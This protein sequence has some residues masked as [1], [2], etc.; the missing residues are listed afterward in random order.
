[1]ERQIK[2][3]SVSVRVALMWMLMGILPF[4]LSAQSFKL[5]NGQ[6]RITVTGTSSLHDWEELAEQKSGAIALDLSG[7]TPSIKSLVLVVEAESLKSGKSA[8]D[9][10]TYKALNT[11]K[12][13]QIAYT[14]ERV[15]SISAN[16]SGHSVVAVGQLTISGKTNT[17]E[18]DL[19]LSVSGDIVSLK[20]SK[21][22]KFTDFALEPPK[23]LMGTIK[24]GDE[25][26]VHFDTVWKK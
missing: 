6:S 12:Y 10:N 25:I 19:D 21:P 17:I 14:L 16:G 8:M 22:L 13:K 24:T 26:M 18:I 9:K 2:K 5:D 11:D 15:K 23:A 20:G 3:S 7:E 1:M 4:G